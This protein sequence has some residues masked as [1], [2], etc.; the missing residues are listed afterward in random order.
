M[1]L[2]LLSILRAPCTAHF[3]CREDGITS[4]HPQ[5]LQRFHM[6]AYPSLSTLVKL[7]AMKVDFLSFSR[8]VF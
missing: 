7:L 6:L 5:I 2:I 3:Q 8:Y 4:M 1:E